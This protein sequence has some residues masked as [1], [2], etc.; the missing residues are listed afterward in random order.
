MMN[1]DAKPPSGDAF[2][3]VEFNAFYD[4]ALPVV[5]GYLLRLC[6]GDDEEAWDLTQDAWMALVDRLAQGQRDTATIGWLVAVARS[7]Y[8]DHWR[9]RQRLQRKLRL[10]WAAE[11][12]RTPCEMTVRDVLDHLS[13]CTP[14]HRLVLMLAYV[15]DLPIAEIATAI[16]SSTSST[17]ALLARARAELRRH[18]SGD[19]DD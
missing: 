6:G 1:A 11:R 8:L 9:R 4:A 19:R 16:G 14:D 7:R 10:V 15:D 18:L 2:S 12:E 13:A 17:Y 3:D 5:Y